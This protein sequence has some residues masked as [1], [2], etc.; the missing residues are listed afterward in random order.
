MSL[1]HFLFLAFFLLFYSSVCL[2]SLIFPL[3]SF[4]FSEIY[5]PCG[6][7]YRSLGPPLFSPARGLVSEDYLICLGPQ[8]GLNGQQQSTSQPGNHPSAYSSK[9]AYN[10]VLQDDPEVASNASDSDA[11]RSSSPVLSQQRH[12][13]QQ[14]P[15]DADSLGAGHHLEPARA[16][17]DISVGDLVSMIRSISSASYDMVEEDDD[18]EEPTIEPK[19]NSSH[20]GL[21]PIDTATT[22]AAAS[23]NESQIQPRSTPCNVS[24]DE[25]PLRSPVSDKPVPLSHPTPD[26]QSLQGAY[27]G[28]VERLERSAEQMSAGS[29]DIASEIRKMDLEQKRR[30]STASVANSAINLQSPRGSVR[31]ATRMPSSQLALLTEDGYERQPFHD[32]TQGIPVIL[33]PP[34][35]IQYDN[36]YYPAHYDIER[37]S[38]AASGDTYQQARIL[39][40]DFDGVHY[41]PQG[42]GQGIERQAPLARPPMAKRSKPYRAESMVYYPAPVPATLKLPPRLSDKPVPQRETRRTHRLS[43]VFLGQRRSTPGLSDRFATPRGTDTTQSSP[44]AALDRMLDDSVHAPVT[45][46]IQADPSPR[47]PK[48]LHRRMPSQNLEEQKKKRSSRSLF[49]FHKRSRSPDDR[50]NT[51]TG[52][53]SQGHLSQPTEVEVAEAHENTALQNDAAHKQEP[54]SAGLDHSEEDIRDY[55]G[56]PNTL[57]AELEVRKHELKH[58]NRPAADRTG[59]RST[60]LQ[61]DAVAQVQSE[62]RRQRPATIALDHHDTH[63]GGNDHDDEDVPLG[64]LYPEKPYIP[65]EPRPLGLLE[66]KQLEEDEPL[67]RRRARLRGEQPVDQSPD[68]SQQAST[69]YLSDTLNH[70]GPDSGDEEETLA[71]RLKR[72]RVKNRNSTAGNSDFASEVFAE[73]NHFKEGEKEDGEASGEETLAQIRARLRQQDTKKPQSGRYANISQNRRSMG[74]ISLLRPAAAQRQ[75]STSHHTVP[76]YAQHNY[77]GSRMSLQQMPPNYGHPHHV[78]YPMQHAYGNGMAHP[79]MAYRSCMGSGASH[80]ATTGALTTDLP[81]R[82]VIDRWRQSVM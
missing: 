64:M 53:L 34:A 54:D 33:Q 73:I 18:Y 24:P 77:A 81:Q 25:P 71:Q 1:Q 12:G 78:G 39:F 35:A 60:L 61:L 44:V 58:R 62:H 74:S 37:P 47:V 72:L 66:K 67:S 21:P 57:M 40:S 42:K 38:S 6:I 28:N 7:L 8:S 68:L 43:S 14:L 46:P 56:A 52:H 11:S 13:F 20:R 19:S 23:P 63:N 2:L 41:V 59:L 48:T 3:H 79:N 75:S 32:P 65:V 10:A 27:V 15:S 26:L 5:F 50:L 49:R 9:M 16:A 55:M 29:S 69:V 36:Q 80:H 4:G 17:D 22:I 51:S 31:S 30:S 82:E 70:A 45:A 76:P